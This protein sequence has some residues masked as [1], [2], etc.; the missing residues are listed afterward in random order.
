MIREA[1]SE[2]LDYVGDVLGK[3][4]QIGGQFVRRLIRHGETRSDMGQSRDL[5][6]PTCDSRVDSIPKCGG[7]AHTCGNMSHPA[8]VC[9]I[10]VACKCA[11]R[12]PR[13]AAQH[14]TNVDLSV[15]EPIS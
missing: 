4:T 5:H 13:I 14:P 6:G 1:D 12:P 15:E 9:H 7:S 10:H 3:S 11:P 8:T 2:H